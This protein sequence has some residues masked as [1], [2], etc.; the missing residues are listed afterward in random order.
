MS[1]K[2]SDIGLTINSF[3]KIFYNNINKGE[4]GLTIIAEN[5]DAMLFASDQ[6][7]IMCIILHFSAILKSICDSLELNFEQVEDYILNP[8]S[9]VLLSDG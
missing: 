3:F 9:F 7:D 8:I 2:I 5:L 1:D 6:D 4:E